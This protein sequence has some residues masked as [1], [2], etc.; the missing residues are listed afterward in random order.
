MGLLG[1]I[2]TNSKSYSMDDFDK[3]VR[4]RIEHSQ[5]KTN[6]NVSEDKSL[7]HLT[8]YACARVLAE[9]LASLPLHV[10]KRRADGGAEKAR[11]HPVYGLL[12]DLPN[13]EMTSMTWRESQMGH[14]VLS[15]NNY[16][17]ITLDGYG[18]VVDIYPL[19]WN[20]VTV[21]RHEI[22]NRIVYDVND[23]GKIE[24]FPA[25]K[26]FHVP[27]W[28]FDGLKGYSPI[29]MAASA[30][31]T[32]L[33]SQDFV[34]RF[35]SQGMNI[36][37]VLEHPQALGDKAYERLLEWIQSKGAG[38]ANSWKPMILEEG[39]KI[40][41]IPMHFVDA[42]FIE[43]QEL[44]RDEIC[45]IFR[46][47]PHMVANLKNA[48]FSNI[49]HQDLAY[50]KHT[51]LPYIQRWEQAINWKLFTPKERAEGYYA[52][53]NV[54]GLL[55][56]D[57]KTRQE[58][59]A[60]QRQNGALNA[61]EWRAEEERNPIEGRAGEAYLVNGNMTPTDIANGKPSQ[62]RSTEGGEE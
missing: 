52:K 44:T 26:I 22:T 21:R 11:D 15:G 6:T 47:P 31:G 30:I 34:N 38:L 41:R 62:T 39:M 42:Q 20:T 23:R 61:N 19:D 12:H 14:H 35:Y 28:G 9:G 53:H 48:T 59:L 3:E 40:N 45:G 5:S 24:T 58:G 7:K 36:G 51:L 54:E 50:V 32:G 49:E 13:N 1:S 60:I 10:Y 37:A 46:V 4:Q 2:I 55:R 56:G 25:E 17:L 18:R 33:S 29:R 8:V 43:T 27:G 57:Y 16:S